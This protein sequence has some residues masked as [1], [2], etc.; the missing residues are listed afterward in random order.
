MTKTLKITTITLLSTTFIITMLTLMPSMDEA[1]AGVTPF[2]G[3]QTLKECTKVLLGDTQNCSASFT[4]A[5][6]FG[7]EVTVNE[8]CD[9][10]EGVTNCMT[11]DPGFAVELLVGGAT[12]ANN[13]TELP[14]QLPSLGDAV[15]FSVE[16]HTMNTP[17]LIPDNVTVTFTDNCDSGDINCN[18]NPLDQQAGAATFVENPSIS[19][20]KAPHLKVAQGGTLQVSALVTNT[21]NIG[22]TNVQANDSEAAHSRWVATSRRDGH[23]PEFPTRPHPSLRC[24]SRRAP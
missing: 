17:G 1:F 24:R 9:T 22:L 19:V 18:P 7:D 20:N 16:D 11:T 14:C 2:H 8:V 21:G 3:G 4:N 6:T 5:D 23:D 12:C 10:S 15:I 13:N